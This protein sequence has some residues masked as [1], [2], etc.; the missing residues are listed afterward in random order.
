[1]EFK[2]LYKARIFDKERIQRA[3]DNGDQL[4]IQIATT[5]FTIYYLADNFENA[6]G[7]A[8]FLGSRRAAELDR[9]CQFKCKNIEIGSVDLVQEEI[10]AD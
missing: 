7:R 8:T 5:G 2:N 4:M 10:I 1:M 3:K 9:S 6:F